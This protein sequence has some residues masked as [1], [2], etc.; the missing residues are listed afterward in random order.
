MLRTA[1]IALL[2]LTT[3]AMAQMTGALGP[4]APVLKRNVTVASDVV[5][6]G[7]FIENAGAA[8]DIPIFRAPDLGS[9]GSVAA[10][11]VLQAARAHD[12]LGIQ[13]DGISEV[14]VTRASRAIPPKEIENLIAQ[15][16][17]DQRG[18]PDAANLVIKLERAVRTIQ[19]EP[20]AKATLQVVRLSDDPRSGSFDIVFELPNSAVARTLPLRFT[21]TA[22]EVVQTVSLTRS[23]TRGDILRPSDIAVG[24]R[25]KAEVGSDFV[26]GPALAVGMALRR[27]MNAGEM[28]R[29]TDL[30]KP[31]LVRRNDMV[32]LVFEIPGI[33]L[34]S[35]GKAM[36][37]GA[38]GDAVAVVNTQ[39]NRT[40]Q[41][42]VTAPGTVTVASI[43]PRFA[44]N[45]IS[46]E[47]AGPAAA[48]HPRAE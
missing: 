25:P 38:Q 39:S 8:A 26:R 23:L 32:A 21:G 24:R 6:I 37:S 42:T 44:A 30:A 15:A 19:V 14:T 4:A 20:T 40:V 45:L 28:L 9:T 46:S 17:A 36:E 27:S 13:A 22:V 18:I 12:L 5:N 11:R 29:R 1:L 41:G 47:T 48:P 34:T 2:A 31:E 43:A 33:M 10:K 16:I 7:D 3:P 35:R